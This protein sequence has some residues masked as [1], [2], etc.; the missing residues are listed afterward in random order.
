LTAEQKHNISHRGK[1]LR[2]FARHLNQQGFKEN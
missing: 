2:A 1:V